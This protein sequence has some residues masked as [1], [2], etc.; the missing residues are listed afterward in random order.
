MTNLSDEKRE[1]SVKNYKLILGSGSPRRRELM[2]RIGA[3]YIII[4]SDKDEDMSGSNPAE[5]VKRLSRMKAEDVAD[6]T[7]GKIKSGEL[8]T[9]YSNSII[10]GCDTVVAY[11]NKILGKPHSDDEAFSMIKDFQGKAHNV[12]TGVCLVIIEDCQIADIRNYS[13]CTNVH[14]AAMTDEEIHGYVSTGE[15]LD[16]AGAYAIQGL[17]CPFITAIEGDYYNIVGFPIN[18][19]YETFKELNIRLF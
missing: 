2:D 14:V 13:V 5:V 18:S 6:I 7:I 16:K 9:E 4:K 1:F 15:C 11:D 8:S 17:F 12:F 3:E 10:I 19:I